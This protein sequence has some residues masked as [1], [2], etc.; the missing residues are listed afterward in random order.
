MS[1]CR[2]SRNAR[3]YA[4]EVPAAFQA[5]PPTM[6]TRTKPGVKRGRNET[7]R[8]VAR[9]L[10]KPEL[11]AVS[12][13]PGGEIDREKVPSNVQTITAPDLDHAKTDSLLEGMVRSL[14]GV[15]LS[16]QPGHAFQ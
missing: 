12:P 3:S 6:L 4:Q 15:S 7:A 2:L 11:V 5:L 14:P 10:P 9:A 1:M 13:V 8:R 16:D